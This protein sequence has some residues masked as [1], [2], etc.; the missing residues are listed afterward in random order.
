MQVGS[1]T[2]IG[3]EGIL[4]RFVGSSLPAWNKGHQCRYGC[5]S[6]GLKVLHGT[7][8]LVKPDELSEDPVHT[9]PLHADDSNADRGTTNGTQKRLVIPTYLAE[10]MVGW[11][12][13]TWGEGVGILLPWLKTLPSIV[14]RTWC[15]KIDSMPFPLD[16]DLLFQC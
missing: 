5:T 13:L 14:L 16:L 8:S 4:Y 12:L 10:G 1:G 6:I 15:A 3:W 2:N 9:T 11:Y 7:T